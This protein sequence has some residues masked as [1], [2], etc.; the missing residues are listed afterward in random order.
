MIP[1]SLQVVC[2]ITATF[3][4]SIE[5]AAVSGW[6]LR[7][8]SET[9]I[10]QRAWLGESRAKEAG[11]GQSKMSSVGLIKWDSGVAIILEHQLYFETRE[12]VF[13]YSPISHI[14]CRPSQE[15]GGKEQGV[16]D[17]N[18]WVKWLW[19]SWEQPSGDS[20]EQL[21]ATAG[22]TAV[23]TAAHGVGARAGQGL[24]SQPEKKSLGQGR[25][26]QRL[27]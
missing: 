4:N 11:D 14:G 6:K 24:M 20:G 19:E 18:S 26:R 21:W 16:R 17:I 8:R 9:G 22:N 25:H 23:F 2:G 3:I 12:T 27:L 7:S 5:S 1:E 13:L 10:W 15:T